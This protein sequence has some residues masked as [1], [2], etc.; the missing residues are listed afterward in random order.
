MNIDDL[1]LFSTATIYEAQGAIGAMASEIKPIVPDMRILGPA[2]TVEIPPGDNLAIHLAVAQAKPGEILVVSAQGFKECG[3]WGDILTLAAKYKQI[4]GV[5]IDGSVRDLDGIIALGLPVF[6][7]GVSV[8]APIKF[9]KGRINVPVVCGGVVVRPHDIVTGDRDGV[10]V[11]TPES[12]EE[13]LAGCVARETKENAM[14]EGIVHGQTTIELLS[15]GN[16][17]GA[18]ERRGTSRE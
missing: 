5:V 17:C 15:L 6:A 11:S 16:L 1:K 4:G 13:V 2:L 3:V 7:R 14:R 9:G 10:I 18:S 12:L 8:K